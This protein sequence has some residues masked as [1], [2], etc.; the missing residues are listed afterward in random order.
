MSKSS[1]ALAGEI[2][3][4]RVEE[5][6][7][8]IPRQGGMRVPGRIFATEKLLAPERRQQPEASDE[9]GPPPRHCRLLSRDAG[10]PLGLRFSHWRRGGHGAERG[11]DLSGR[12]RLR[13]KLWCPP[14]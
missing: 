7:W 1:E 13:H 10:H 3:L 9:R 8:E 12:R 6:L 2:K 5:F 14:G 4:H 11:G